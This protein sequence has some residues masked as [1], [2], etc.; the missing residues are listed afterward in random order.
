MTDD[1]VGVLYGS[2]ARGDADSLSDV[3]VL[4]IGADEVEVPKSAMP[5]GAQVSQYDWAEWDELVRTG[6]IFLHHL[7]GESRVLWST[8]EGATR[9]E[10]SLFNLPMYGHVDRDFDAF[11]EAIDT[12]DHEIYG[13]GAAVE[14]ELSLL[15]MVVRHSSILIC[16]LLGEVNFSRFQSLR[17]AVEATGVAKSLCEDFEYLYD[18]RL[19][20]L[21]RTANRPKLPARERVN[22]WIDESRHLVEAG[23]SLGV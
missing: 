19:F 7:K 2:A 11:A 23:R 17:N 1:T 20:S 4:L 9:Y 5:S 14:F 3:D 18:F 6:S 16:Y 13:E 8:G 22:M 15:A 12:I 21:G 10:S